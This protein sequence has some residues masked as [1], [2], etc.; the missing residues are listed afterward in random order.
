MEF[1][2]PHRRWAFESAALDLA[3]RQQGQSLG[4]AL[5]REYRP[6]RFV[7]STRL[8]ITPWLAVDPR[9]EFKLDPTP[10]WDTETMK[11]IAATGRVRVLD[12][13]SFYGGSPVDNPPDPVQYR[14]AAAA[15]PDA[16]LADPA[17][18][19]PARDALVG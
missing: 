11:R 8:D 14:A 9:L 3:L 17:L 16:I 5:G 2:R 6:L 1:F 13:K 18:T 10:E 7:V 15:F 12:F 19:G 4:A